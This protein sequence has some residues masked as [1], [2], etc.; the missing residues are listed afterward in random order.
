MNFAIHNGMKG[1]ML[2]FHPWLVW[3][4]CYA[5]QL[6]L[7]YKNVLNSNLFK[8]V[9]EML[10]RLFYLYEESPKKMRE[11]EEIV[12]ELREVYEFPKGGI[13]P[14]RSQGSTINVRHFNVWLISMEHA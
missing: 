12:K 10:L 11:L 2:D 5:H 9:D 4:W 8:D 1:M 3:S 7:A 6:E 13:R 14:F